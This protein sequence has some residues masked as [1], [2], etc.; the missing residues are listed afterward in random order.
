MTSV[1][2]SSGRLAAGSARRTHP[3]GLAASYQPL[4]QRSGGRC[5]PLDGRR[6]LRHTLFKFEQALETTN[7]VAHRL[8]FR[9]LV[10]RNYHVEMIL[11]VCDQFSRVE[12]VQIE[13]GN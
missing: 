10:H 1:F 4:L 11:N 2:N 9:Q 5:L 3:S 7:D 13:V 12:R 6:S 8:H